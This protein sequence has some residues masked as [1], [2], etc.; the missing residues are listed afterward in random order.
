MVD[1]AEYVRHARVRPCNR[2][3]K[4]AVPRRVF[5]GGRRLVD[6]LPGPAWNGVDR[7]DPGPASGRNLRRVHLSRYNDPE[8]ASVLPHWGEPFSFDAE[9]APEIISDHF[10][11]TEVITWDTPAVRLLTVP[12][13]RN[14]S[15]AAGQYR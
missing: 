1:R 8:F 2:R 11:I 13:W 3:H 10:T 12:R 6:V 7:I 9:T 5:R 4:A 15:A 14:S